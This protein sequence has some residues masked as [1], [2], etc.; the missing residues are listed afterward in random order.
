MLFE[1]LL[2]IK[3]KMFMMM[4]IEDTSEKVNFEKE[5]QIVWGASF[6]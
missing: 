4:M 6:N 5:G 1:K 2:L 3:K